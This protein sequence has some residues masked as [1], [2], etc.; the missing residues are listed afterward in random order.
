MIMT[1]KLFNNLDD[2]L[3]HVKKITRKGRTGSLYVTEDYFPAQ[4]ND[5]IGTDVM[6]RYRKMGCSVYMG[7]TVIYET[8][9]CT[10]LRCDTTAPYTF[11]GWLNRSGIVL[12]GDSRYY[13]TAILAEA[14]QMNEFLLVQCEDF[15]K[16]DDI[17]G[18]TSFI[19]RADQSNSDI[20]VLAEVLPDTNIIRFVLADE[21]SVLMK[22]YQPEPVAE[23]KTL[24]MVNQ[25]I[26]ELLYSNTIYKSPFN[27]GE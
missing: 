19:I 18:Y 24:K 22:N 26:K 25:F 23:R 5:I 2:T 10:V 21:T 14:G 12:V 17:D 6:V 1:S 8:K 20:V 16:C 15:Y 3:E 7:N 11:I 13:D 27:E 9:H 4:N